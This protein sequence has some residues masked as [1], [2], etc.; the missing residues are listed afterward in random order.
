MSEK[1]IRKKLQGNNNFNPFNRG[2]NADELKQYIAQVKLKSDDDKYAKTIADAAEIYNFYYRK[3]TEAIK[4]KIKKAYI[5]IEDAIIMIFSMANVDYLNLSYEA[6]QSGEGVSLF[7]IAHLEVD[8]PEPHFGKINIVGAVEGQVDYIN[9]I[10]NIIRHI[11][12]DENTD[13]EEDKIHI[14]HRG[15]V[16]ANILYYIKE[17]Y[18]VALWEDGYIKIEK[19]KICVKYIDEK[20]PIAKH[21]GYL[22]TENNI[23]GSISVVEKL[24]NINKYYKKY[25]TIG[26]SDYIIDKAWLDEEGYIQYSLIK[27]EN[28]YED[29]IPY[30][31]AKTEVDVYYPF[32]Y[33]EKIEEIKELSIN[34][35]IIMFTRLS[36]LINKIVDAK[37]ETK[38]RMS[39]LSVKISRKDIVQLLKQTTI[40]S[41]KQI[42]LFLEMNTN[43]MDNNC[44]INLR[45]K[46][47][48]LLG[49]TYLC[50]MSAIATPNYSYLADVWLDAAGVDLTRRGK[51]FERY[52]KKSL[53]EVLA[54]K[55]YSYYIP[56]INKFTNKD[57]EYEEIDLLINLKNIVVIA[58]VK[59]IKYAME[60]R[61]T[62]NN[63]KIIKIAANQIKRKADFI[64]MYKDELS[65][66]IGDMEGKKIIKA[67]I[68]NYPIFAGSDVDDIP[69]IDFYL[70]DSYFRSGKLT[71]VALG[72]NNVSEFNVIPY[73]SNEDELC[74]ELETFLDNP[75]SID[76]LK[77]KIKLEERKLSL[78]DAELQIF[79]DFPS[80]VVEN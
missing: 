41:K 18:D 35:M 20:Y 50:L 62:H 60:C 3:Y 23:A 16:F 71:H 6:I 51:D 31:M 46:P 61:D 10:I 44:R 58:E 68:T 34:D 54:K 43:E 47:L 49:N 56:Q 17:S 8:S 39:L 19:D 73:Y 12:L 37:I 5:S 14:A 78:P 77:K 55:G 40:Y 1:T 13:L 57:G 59:C 69:I 79:Q 67:I 45:K 64:K 53:E 76:E 63:M 4:D 15:Y 42:E 24:S 38:Q 52:I 27:K 9:T 74:T 25:F 30:V 28:N 72:S 22:R 65:D 80:V 21:I 66:F 7:D 70:F 2:F 75:P 32:I 26:R 36:N 29:D 48:L 33:K 11:V